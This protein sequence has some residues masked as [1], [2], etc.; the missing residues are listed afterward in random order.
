MPQSILC[1]YFQWVFFVNWA[2]DVLVALV[3]ALSRAHTHPPLVS[4]PKEAI[5]IYNLFF[6]I[7]RFVSRRFLYYLCV[8]WNGISI[9]GI[10]FI[11]RVCECALKH[12]CSMHVKCF[13]RCA[14]LSCSM[15]FAYNTLCCSSLFLSPSF[16][17]LKSNEIHNQFWNIFH[18]LCSHILRP[19]SFIIIYTQNMHDA[20]SLTSFG[21]EFFM[22]F[23]LWANL[24]PI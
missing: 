4:K 22:V 11:I 20:I 23:G 15:C 14:C 5:L 8:I 1:F 19:F 17:C 12:M 9:P 10:S 13:G 18:S 16:G 21:N 6:W 24:F 3:K 7:S 2:A